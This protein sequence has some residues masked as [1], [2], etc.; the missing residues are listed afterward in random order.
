MYYPIEYYI[1]DLKKK[2]KIYIY[3][4]CYNFGMSNSRMKHQIKEELDL[5]NK[6]IIN[7]YATDMKKKITNN[8]IILP[9]YCSLTT[10]KNPYSYEKPEM[11]VKIK[12]V[13]P[14][15][16]TIG[17]VTF[18]QAMDVDYNPNPDK[19]CEMVFSLECFQ[20]FFA[21]GEADSLEQLLEFIVFCQDILQFQTTGDNKL[22]IHIPK[23][24]EDHPFLKINKQFLSK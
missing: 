13:H 5:I 19:F 12:C 22:E 16:N 18:W 4:G 11:E 2:L 10:F 1:S 3:K 14:N 17:Y 24:L 21:I 20:N 6:T 15:S 8:E 7:N 9:P 23:H